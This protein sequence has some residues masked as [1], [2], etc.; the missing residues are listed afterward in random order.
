MSAKEKQ[1]AAKQTFVFQRSLTSKQAAK[2]T[3][4]RGSAGLRVLLPAKEKQ[5]AAKQRK[6]DINVRKR[7]GYERTNFSNH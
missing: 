5:A 3:R 4:K 7:D 2:Q 1:A 6:N